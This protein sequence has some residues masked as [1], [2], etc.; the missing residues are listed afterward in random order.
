MLFQET[1][2]SV[3]VHISEHFFSFL[4]D[5]VRMKRKKRD[6][7]CRFPR[8]IKYGIQYLSSLVVK[9]CKSS[10]VMKSRLHFDSIVQENRLD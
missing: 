7:V 1:A 6:Q 9:F 8:V 5:T 2:R 3:T 4:N 10:V